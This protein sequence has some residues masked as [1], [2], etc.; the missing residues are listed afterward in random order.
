MV[1]KSV[2]DLYSMFCEL[3]LVEESINHVRVRGWL[4]SLENRKGAD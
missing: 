1:F 2:V 3:K 4:T